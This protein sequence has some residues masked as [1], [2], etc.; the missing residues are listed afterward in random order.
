MYKVRAAGAPPLAS[1]VN[2]GLF[3]L[4]NAIG[5]RVGGIV[6]AA[7]LG[8]AAPNWA[9]ALLSLIALLLALASGALDGKHSSSA[10]L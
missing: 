5:A 2:I 9:S 8:L 6:I 10:S 3:N 4:G 7:G 1:A